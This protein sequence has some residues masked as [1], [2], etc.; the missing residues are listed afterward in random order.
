MMRKRYLIFG[1]LGLLYLSPALLASDIEPAVGSPGS[2][3][4]QVYLKNT[5][6]EL[7]VYRI[8]GR[9]PGRTLL[10]IGGIHGNEPGG[11]LAAS[12]Y[13]DLSLKQG[14]LIVVP[15]ANLESILK[16]TRGHSGDYNRKFS[17]QLDEN[18][19][20]DKIISVLKQLISES[21]CMINLHDGSGFYRETWI[22]DMHNPY[23]YGQSIIADCD[24]YNVPGSEHTLNLAHIAEAVVG[25]VN[26]D[27][28]RDQFKFR[29]ANHDSVAENTKYPDMRKTA[30]FYALT[31]HHIPAFGVETS[32]SLPSTQLKVEHQILVINAFMEEFDIVPEIPAKQIEQPHFDY[33]VMV[34]NDEQRYVVRNG[35]TLDV[36]QGSIIRVDHIVGNYEDTMFADITGHGGNNDNGL[37]VAVN[38]PLQISI[39]KDAQHCGGV[40]IKP[41]AP[42]TA[43]RVQAPA[44]DHFILRV[45]DSL[46]R[47]EPGEALR[48]FRGDAV[49]IV[50][51][52]SA[53]GSEVS[54]VNLKGFVGKPGDNRGEDRGYTV[55]TTSDLM[56][57]WSLDGRGEKY[58]I[59]AMRPRKADATMELQ[60]INPVVS[61]VL[62]QTGNGKP[63]LVENG[64]EIVLDE[65]EEIALLSIVT[66]SGSLDADS[67]SIQAGSEEY[68]ERLR[69]SADLHQQQ[70]N[71]VRF[72]SRLFSATVKF[73]GR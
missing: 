27:I 28:D 51:F 11:Y 24:I 14:N 59:A 42:A 58:L 67:F 52:S 19:A 30:T 9:A 31:T 54:N 1:L 12:H 61:H 2:R 53:D 71:L 64:G 69:L 18:I 44:E 15:R 5:D 50:D 46:H 49:T 26:Q 20:D 6:N 40:A 10:I 13:V 41:V 60:L 57:D 34:V 48:V 63:L 17:I 38:R 32:K 43:N 4:H 47:V 68:T 73:T 33:L 22:D 23:R 8:Y 45:N 55:N 36:E 39:R 37:E 65:N 29:F 66:P 35:E 7:H 72:G 62:F 56:K 25:R 3:H 16:N 70:L 21:D